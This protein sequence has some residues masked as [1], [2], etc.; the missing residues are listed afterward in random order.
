M[1]T[2]HWHKIGTYTLAIEINAFLPHRECDGLQDSM[3]CGAPREPMLSAAW[4]PGGDG[5]IRGCKHSESQ[6]HPHTLIIISKGLKSGR[7]WRKPEEQSP[8]L[9]EKNK[10][11]FPLCESSSSCESL[12]RCCSCGLEMKGQNS[13][14]V[15]LSVCLCVCIY[16][17]SSPPSL[18][19]W[20]LL[21]ITAGGEWPINLSWNKSNF[22]PG[23]KLCSQRF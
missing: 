12:P 17:K 20:H 13:V 1:T 15:R 23:L 19:P 10:A 3:R 18:H 6:H 21:Q 7:L 4:L 5:E 2:T 14:C 11:P 22:L 8:G 9:R 16:F